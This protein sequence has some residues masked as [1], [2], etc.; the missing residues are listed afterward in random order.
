L[1]R[2][3]KGNYNV[4]CGKCKAFIKREKI[5]GFGAK[6]VCYPCKENPNINDNRQIQIPYHMLHDKGIR[7]GIKV[8]LR[9]NKDKTITIIPYKENGQTTNRSGS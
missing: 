2:I 8:K 7:I 5:R 4:R 3:G 1:R 6:Y 9:L